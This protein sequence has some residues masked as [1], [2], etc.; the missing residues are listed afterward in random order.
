M[1]CI[2]DLFLIDISIFFVQEPSKRIANKISKYQ[3]FFSR[4]DFSKRFFYLIENHL[5]NVL[6]CLLVEITFF[7]KNYIILKKEFPLIS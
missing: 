1:K 2:F 5:N 3:N 4:K 7:R 6:L